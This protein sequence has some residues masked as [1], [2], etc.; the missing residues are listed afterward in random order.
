ML[1]FIDD[2]RNR[3]AITN[4][5]YLTSIQAGFEPWQGGAGLAVTNFS[6]DRQRRR[7]PAA[8]HR[9]AD[10]AARRA[11]AAAARLKYASNSWNNGFTADV[12]VTNTGPAPSTVGP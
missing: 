10:H 12:T 9:A 11:T 8:H 2:V 5:W 7:Q 4:S 1:D 3:G 6:A